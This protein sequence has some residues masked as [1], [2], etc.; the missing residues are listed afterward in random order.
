MMLSRTEIL[1]AIK[2]GEIAITP[3]DKK[4]IGAASVDLHLGS[5]FLVYRKGGRAIFVKEDTVVPKTHLKKVTISGHEVM[6]LKPH[7]FI[8]GV[9]R[10]K[11]KLSGKY[12]GKIE[13][14]SRFAR[15]GLMVHISSS[16]IQ[17]GSNNVQVLEIV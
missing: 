1:R 2:K 5:E 15:L 6:H 4:C 12:A 8:L 11:I 14:R 17:P 7:Q 13:G 3:L 9:T 16:L 10:E